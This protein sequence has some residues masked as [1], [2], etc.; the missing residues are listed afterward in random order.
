MH[1]GHRVDDEVPTAAFAV[2]LIAGILIFLVGAVEGLAS[3][4]ASEVG[5]NLASLALSVVAF[6]GVVFGLIVIALAVSLYRHPEHH[7]GY[8][9]AILV[10]S[11]ASIV[12]GG[13]FGLGLLL[14]V[15]GGILAILFEE[16]EEMDY[17][18]STGTYRPVPVA[19][20]TGFAAP[21]GGVTCPNCRSTVPA[22]APR[23]PD[24]ET[25]LSPRAAA[26]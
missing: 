24:C 10:F 20:P 25:P 5:A 3:S 14:G 17:D 23:C 4:L 2:S 9:I 26:R 11:V 15:V 19:P 7:T 21:S 8:G 22:G 18:P 16:S 6:F 13:G 12:G 1:E